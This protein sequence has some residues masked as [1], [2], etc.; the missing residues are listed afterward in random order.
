MKIELLIIDP[1][2]D[3]CD[4]A[5]GSLYVTNAE[6]DMKRLSYLIIRLNKKISQ[7][8]ITLD[9][10]HKNDLAHPSFWI[11]SN[12]KHPDP[13]ITNITEDDMKNGV[14]KPVN[15]ALFNRMFNYVKELKRTGRYDLTVWVPHCII[16]TPGACINSNILKAIDVWCGE[17]R[18]VDYVT[19]GSNPLTEHYSAVKA[20]VPDPQD[21]TTQLN[22]PLLETLQKADEILIA[23]EAL[24]HCVANTVR[25]IAN[26]F[27]EEN[28]KKLVL[29][30]D[31]SSPV[32]LPVFKQM[33]DDF[34]NEMIGRGMRISTTDKYMI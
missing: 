10:H 22:M 21:P 12:G 9:S 29:L 24:S 19:K 1:Q 16:N 11:N 15:P 28:I 7:I 27:G 32:G 31:A 30:E 26:N 6:S 8:H 33:A 4:P 13:M 17:T 23:G 3:F 18:Y 14:W 20:E 25:D 34:V 2:N 5:S